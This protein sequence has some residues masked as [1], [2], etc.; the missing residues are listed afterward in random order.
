MSPLD[1]P[2]SAAT[3]RTVV[4]AIPR[5][6]ITCSVAATIALVAPKE[7]VNIPPQLRQLYAQ[8]GQPVPESEDPYEYCQ[9]ILEQ[10]KKAEDDDDAAA[11]LAT[12]TGRE[13]A[14]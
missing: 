3:S 6:T 9:R 13:V 14:E 5:R 12:S 7:A 8:L 10:E 4:A 11:Q 1:V 2:I